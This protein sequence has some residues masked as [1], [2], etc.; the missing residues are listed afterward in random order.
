MFGVDVCVDGGVVV[1][2][3]VH[4]GVDV[5]VGVD[6]GA[7]VHVGVD[8]LVVVPLPKNFMRPPSSINQRSRGR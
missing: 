1:G 3:G 7:G 4:V 2:V 8:H 6:G 5:D